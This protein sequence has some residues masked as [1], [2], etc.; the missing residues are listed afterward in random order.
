MSAADA[1]THS[2]TTL[3]VQFYRGN[4]GHQIFD[5]VLAMGG[6]LTAM[7]ESVSRAETGEASPSTMSAGDA[8]PPTFN[9]MIHQD[10][11]CSGT[12][13]VCY[14]LKVLGIVRSGGHA[15]AAHSFALLPFDAEK[16]TLH[17]FEDLVAPKYGLGRVQ[18]GKVNPVVLRS[19]IA[20]LRAVLAAEHADGARALSGAAAIA[21]SASK[22]PRW[23]IYGR[24]DAKR[25]R[26]T[27]SKDVVAELRTAFAAAGEATRAVAVTYVPTMGGLSFKAQMELFVSATVFLAPHGAHMGNSIF[28]GD[29]TVVR[30]LSCTGYSHL[31]IYPG[32][33]KALAIDFVSQVG[34]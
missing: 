30:E 22:A 17:C 16:K 6:V 14:I 20:R 10:P 27:N 33:T 24:E 31:A 9:L 21:T 1:V 19:F 26:W 8:L 7:L 11:D 28:F 29:G 2:G 34:P 13:F 3:L 23:V 4:I 12:S 18:G 15:T 5:S 32:L 25:R